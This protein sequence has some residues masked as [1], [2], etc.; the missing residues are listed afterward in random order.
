MMGHVS[1]LPTHFAQTFAGARPNSGSS[2]GTRLRA[3]MKQQRLKPAVLRQCLHDRFCP[4]N[5]AAGAFWTGT[6]VDRLRI[7]GGQR[8]NGVIRISGAKNAALP[9]MIAS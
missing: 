5:R 3:C 8:L 6:S 9:L 7:V 2:R 1:A 4:S